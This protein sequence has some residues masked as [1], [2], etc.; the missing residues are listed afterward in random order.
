MRWAP[1]GS[2]AKACASWQDIC[3]RGKAWTRRVCTRKPRPRW[4][5]LKPARR[6]QE[7]GFICQGRARVFERYT[8]KARRVIFFARYEASQTGSRHIETEHLLLGIFREDHAFA[9]RV[10]F[11]ATEA[12]RKQVEAAAAGEKIAT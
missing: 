2:F 12:F 3:P 1:S 5:R 8:E 9:A 7:C 6:L 4:R 10:G 11:P